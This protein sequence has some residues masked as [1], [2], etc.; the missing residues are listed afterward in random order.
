MTFNCDEMNVQKHDIKYLR[1]V[2]KYDT[3]RKARKKEAEQKDRQ[4][5]QERQKKWESQTDRKMDRQ[6]KYQKD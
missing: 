6:T 2:L 4:T 5:D 3:K 1:S